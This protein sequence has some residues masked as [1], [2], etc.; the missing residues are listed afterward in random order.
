MGAGE[1]QHHPTATAEDIAEMCAFC[2]SDKLTEKVEA[3]YNV[4]EIR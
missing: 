3:I 4:S 2:G 1:E